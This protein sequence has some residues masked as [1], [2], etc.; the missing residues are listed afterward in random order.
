MRKRGRLP[1]NGSSKC[2]LLV[3]SL[4]RLSLRVSGVGPFGRDFG[5]LRRFEASRGFRAS[6]L[7]VLVSSATGSEH[8]P[9]AEAWHRTTRE[10]D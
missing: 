6:V 5:V 4:L 7:G 8:S 1:G 10:T 9:E 2:L 3:M